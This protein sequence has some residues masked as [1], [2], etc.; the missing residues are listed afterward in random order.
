MDVM[1]L[2]N[3]ELSNQPTCFWPLLDQILGL[4]ICSTYYVENSTMVLQ[5]LVDIFREPFKFNLFL[6]KSDPSA[7][8]YIFKYYKKFL[9]VN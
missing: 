3:S 4:K 9:K 2:E 8:A 6:E 7:T 1:F 5:S